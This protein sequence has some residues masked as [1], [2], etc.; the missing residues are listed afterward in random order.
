[1]II[2]EPQSGLANRMRVVASGL[3]LQKQVGGDLLCLWLR[4]DLL[5]APFEALFE[6]IP[7]WEIQPAARRFKFVQASRRSRPFTMALAQIINRMLGVD[8]CIAEPDFENWLWKNKVNLADV[9]REHGTLYIQTCQEFGHN[10][11]EFRNFAPIPAL[12][13]KIHALEKRFRPQTIGIHIRR[14]DHRLSIEM[15]PTRLFIEKI[16]A[17]ITRDANALFYLSTDDADVE[18]EFRRRYG[19]RILTHAKEF[20]RQTAA[21]IQDAVVDLF[22]LSKTAAI[23]GSYWSSFSDV[24]ARIGNIPFTP[25]TK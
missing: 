24:A 18:Q 3:Q 5:N 14:T 12:R 11:E 21:G 7:G 23:Y 19:E 20:S 1:M 8:F 9:A 15:S 10:Q 22:C 25:L 16:D 13:H 2:L 17:E 4:N 6:S